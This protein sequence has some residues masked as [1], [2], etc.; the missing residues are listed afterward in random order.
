MWL[1][2]FVNDDCIFERRKEHD[3]IQCKNCQHFGHIARN[4]SR[5]FRCVK[6]LDIHN[7]GDCPTDVLP[8]QDN[9]RRKPTCVNCGKEHPA[10][11]RGCQAHIDLIKQKQ[12]R[13]KINEEKQRFRQQSANTY[14]SADVNFSQAVRSG[15]TSGPTNTQRQSKASRPTEVNNASEDNCLNFLQRECSSLFGTDLFAL[16]RRIRS[17]APTYRTLSGEQKQQAL[18]ELILSI[19]PI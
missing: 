16:Q 3:T 11:Y 4:C 9:N 15:S 8:L 1:S 14:R 5:R 10:N 18:I 2:S 7:P 6:C 17:F 13:I 19:T 12:A